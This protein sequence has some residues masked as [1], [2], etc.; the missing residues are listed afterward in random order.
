MNVV[1]KLYAGY[2]EGAPQG[3]GPTKAVSRQRGTRIWRR[4]SPSWTTSRQHRSPSSAAAPTSP[5]NAGYEYQEEVGPGAAGRT[6]LAWLSVR[7]RHSTEAVWRQRIAAG[8]V[9][10]DGEPALARAVLRSGQS[11]VWRRPPWDE[12]VVPLGFA[13]LHRDDHLLAVAKPRGLP[14]VPNGGFLEHTLLYRV[15]RLHPEA[16]PVHRLGRGTSGL[17][18][19]A[20]TD[21][22]RR[23]LAALW[24]TGQ[25]AEGVP[26]ARARNPRRRGRSRW[27]RRSASSRTRASGRCTR[28][29]PTASRPS[30]TCASWRFGRSRRWSRSR[31]RPA[32]RTRSASTSPRPATRWSPIRCTSRAAGPAP[33][34][35]FPARAA[36]ASTPTGSGSSTRPPGGGSIRVPAA[37]RAAGLRVSCQTAHGRERKA[38][39][40][41]GPI[42]R[43]GSFSPRSIIRAGRSGLRV[44]ERRRNGL[45]SILRMSDVVMW[46]LKVRRSLAVRMGRSQEPAREQRSVALHARP[47]DHLTRQGG[48]VDVGALE[49]LV[50][51]ALV[52]DDA[53]LHVFL[54]KAACR[55][56]RTD[57]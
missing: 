55:G 2:G 35:R 40:G 13:I 3:R 34:L 42:S 56:R 5:V 47:V 39:A 36:T 53:A 49:P 20:R 46:R 29:R 26:G 22:A 16:V 41:A 38:Q 14:S 31:Y 30:R 10:L 45:A 24:R 32:G 51:V 18:L 23:A 6:V 4:A 21:G 33:I 43:T 28:P 7:W 1:E 15:R 17:V 19:F 57:D 11:L 25:G 50:P 54:S 52:V 48:R 8:E 44:R 12:P 37:A 9:R 27:R